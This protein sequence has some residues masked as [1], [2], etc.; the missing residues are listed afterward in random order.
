M[1]AQGILPETPDVSQACER[2]FLPGRKRE[3][4]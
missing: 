1:A 2:R 4:E 3:E